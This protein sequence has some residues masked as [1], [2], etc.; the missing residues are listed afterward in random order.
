ME[1]IG[2]E[3]RCSDLEGGG[4]SLFLNI[5]I[6]QGYALFIYLF[7]YFFICPSVRL[8]IY[9]FNLCECVYLFNNALNGFIV[10]F[11]SKTK[12]MEKQHK[13]KPPVGY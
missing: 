7:I 4:S 12:F 1:R 10:K 6:L 5:G 13:N 2:P 9:L 3:C 8:F 11:S